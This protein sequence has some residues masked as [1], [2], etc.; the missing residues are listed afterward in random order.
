MGVIA[1]LMHTGEQ[2][3]AHLDSLP[4]EVIIKCLS[5]L[6][7][8]C[9]NHEGNRHFFAQNMTQVMADGRW[10]IGDGC[11]YTRKSIVSCRIEFKCDSPRLVPLLL[12]VLSFVS[13]APEPAC[14]SLRRLA[15]SV[16]AAVSQLNHLLMLMLMRGGDDDHATKGEAAGAGGVRDIVEEGLKLVR[17]ACTKTESSKGARSPAPFNQSISQMLTRTISTPLSATR[18]S[19]VSRASVA[20]QLHKRIRNSTLA[21]TS[22]V[23]YSRRRR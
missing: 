16:C 22:H 14:D 17:V 9:R 10:T 3:E 2:G 20:H 8:A 11:K 1:G 4:Y 12:L 5:T 19:C 18:Q 6:Q 13:L 23:S 7:D 21:A 15:L